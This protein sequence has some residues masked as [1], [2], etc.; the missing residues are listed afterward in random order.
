M[1]CSAVLPVKSLCQCWSKLLCPIHCMINSASIE[2]LIFLTV[3]HPPRSVPHYTLNLSHM[4]RICSDWSKLTL[5]IIPNPWSGCS[6]NDSI[7]LLYFD[8]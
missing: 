7:I 8:C 6:I 5:P 4:P 2:M 1:F 3:T